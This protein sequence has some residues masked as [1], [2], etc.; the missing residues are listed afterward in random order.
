MHLSERAVAAA[1][2][3][4]TKLAGYVVVVDI[5]ALGCSAHLA[6]CLIE[7]NKFFACDP[8][9]VYLLEASR[10]NE[11]VT[12]SAITVR[13]GTHALGYLAITDWLIFG[14]AIPYP[15]L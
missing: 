7:R 14:E 4:A 1:A 3:N 5:Y 8:V 9:S 6:V 11:C 2:Q 12:N 10:T 15:L 13:N